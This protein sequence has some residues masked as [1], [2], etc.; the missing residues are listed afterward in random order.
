M[1]SVLALDQCAHDVVGQRPSRAP[2]YGPHKRGIV[3]SQRC[4]I[5]FVREGDALR[6]QYFAIGFQMDSLVIDDD[7]VKV[8]KDRFDH[9]LRVISEGPGL[10]PS[11]AARSAFQSY[12]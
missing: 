5:V 9:W 3:H 12:R 1:Q 7:A 8:K 4:E 6:G 2:I 10:K 11:K